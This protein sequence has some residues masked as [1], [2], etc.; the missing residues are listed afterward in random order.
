MHL[1]NGTAK[2]SEAVAAST[3]SETWLLGN[4]LSRP[5]MGRMASIS[6]SLHLSDRSIASLSKKDQRSGTGKKMKNGRLTA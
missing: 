3:I 4:E 5:L 6:L 2:I 1:R